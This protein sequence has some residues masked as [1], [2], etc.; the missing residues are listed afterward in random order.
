MTEQRRDEFRRTVFERDNNTCT[1]P[2]CTRTADDAHH[3]IER[4]YWNNGGYIPDNGAS[5]CNHHHQHAE[6]DL[7]PPQSFWRWIGITNPPL[8][9]GIDTIHIN[10][11][12]DKLDTP[13]W[14]EHRQYIKYPS[15]RHL[16]FSHVGDDDDTQMKHVDRF[17]DAPL[18]ITEKLDGS[19]AML[20]QDVDEPVRSRRGRKATHKS[21][22]LLHD[23]Y[24]SYNIHEKLPDNIQVF[25]EWLYAKHSIHYGC[26]CTPS[27][28]DAASPLTNRLPEDA[29]SDERAY[30]Q[31]F[32]VYDM[33]YDMWLSWET[34]QV[35]AEKL[36]FPTAPVRRVTDDEDAAM[37]TNESKF[38]DDVYDIAQSVISDGGEGIVVR[39]KYPFHYGQFSE[40]VG[41]YV[42]ENHVTTS[43]HWR[44]Q[45]VTQNNL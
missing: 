30:F 12:T 32:G 34:T 19:N 11:W 43:E 39:S 35:V 3:I 42:R 37:F 6:R 26:T 5:V 8:P 4:D 10:K 38:Y 23:I 20:I 45:S 7:I 1:V 2:W 18:V 14:K 31:V 24:W 40:R 41:K 25:G 22:D 17:L 29:P 33:K 15:T 9:T 21:F 36:G 28:D 44:H 27:C 13:P 16:P